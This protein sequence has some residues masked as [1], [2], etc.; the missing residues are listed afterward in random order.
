[1]VRKWL[2]LK[3]L[4]NKK[5]VDNYLILCYKLLIRNIKSKKKG[6]YGIINIS[7]KKKWLNLNVNIKLNY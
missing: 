2:K 5:F 6:E 4:L 7:Y 3:I 1:M